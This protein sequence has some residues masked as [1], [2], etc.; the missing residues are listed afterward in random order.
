MQVLFEESVIGLDHRNAGSARTT[1]AGVVRKKRC[2]DMNEIEAL[3]A[4]A[5]QRALQVTPMH[6]AVFRITRHA[7]RCDADQ[8][9]FITG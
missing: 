5:A 7:A 4:Q 3:I 6:A 8:S 2:L 9:R 1:H